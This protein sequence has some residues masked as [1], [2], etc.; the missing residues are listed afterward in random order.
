MIWRPRVESPSDTVKLWTIWFARGT[1][2]IDSV[3]SP[4]TF[5]QVEL[6]PSPAPG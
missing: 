3:R 5:V 2:Q 6:A 1:E 4:Q